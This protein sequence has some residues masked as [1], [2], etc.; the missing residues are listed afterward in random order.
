MDDDG[1]DHATFGMALDGALQV[2]VAAGLERNQPPLG[3]LTRV[4]LYLQYSTFDLCDTGSAPVTNLNH[5]SE[6]AAGKIVQ[7]ETTRTMYR[8]HGHLLPGGEG[9]VME[10]QSVW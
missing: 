2:I 3:P 9:G 8:L 1:T 10:M 7:R 4:D 5:A 6:H